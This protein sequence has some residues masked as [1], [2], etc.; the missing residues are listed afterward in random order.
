LIKRGVVF[1]DDPWEE[2]MAEGVMLSLEGGINGI[3]P[4]Y[5]I[6][7]DW[8]KEYRLKRFEILR[9]ARASAASTVKK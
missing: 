7:R 6:V 4:N 8:A 2:C 3:Q 1:L 9:I 5:L